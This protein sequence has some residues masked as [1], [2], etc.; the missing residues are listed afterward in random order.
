MN[1]VGRCKAQTDPTPV[2]QDPDGE[3][4]S[5]ETLE[6]GGCEGDREQKQGAATGGIDACLDGGRTPPGLHQEDGQ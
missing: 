2:A 6:T 5:P 1:E 3:R 4:C